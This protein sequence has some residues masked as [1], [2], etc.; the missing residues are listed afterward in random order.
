[1]FSDLIANDTG[2]GLFV[3]NVY[4]P[5]SGGT[6]TK[7]SISF[8]YYPPVPPVIDTVTYQVLDQYAA[9]STATITINP[10]TTAPSTGTGGGSGGGTPTP[11]GDTAIRQIK[12]VSGTDTG[13]TVTLDAAPAQG[14][15]LIAFM[16]QFDSIGPST[17]WTRFEFRYAGT[18]DN[19]AIAY[20]IVG[21]NEPRLQQPFDLSYTEET[22][23]IFE[24]ANTT[25]EG[26]AGHFTEVDISTPTFSRA[27]P[28]STG[29][30]VIGVALGLGGNVPSVSGAGT[31]ASV[32]GGRATA[33]PF[34]SD[35]A[36]T[37]IAAVPTN[38]QPARFLYMSVLLNPGR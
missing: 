35:I 29:Q 16:P 2:N 20:R 28:C 32:K 19:A 3:N 37:V 36:T 22:V 31:L 13:Q 6:I 34:F 18:R 8:T 7:D 26:I 38:Q 5:T 33:Q 1:M 25:P 23:T 24:I 14:S 9:P 12:S 10:S 30:L 15:L 11:V 27:E 4:N 17:G 21:A